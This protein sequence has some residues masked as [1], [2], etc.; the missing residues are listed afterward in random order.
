MQAYAATRENEDTG[1]LIASDETQDPTKFDDKRYH[2]A[3]G[4][5]IG[6]NHFLESFVELSLCD[7]VLTPPSTFAVFAAFLGDIPI[8]PLTE[9]SGSDGWEHLENNLFDALTHPS[10]S[11][12]VQ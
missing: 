10:L 5:G 9:N 7:L 11:E 2:F 6:S 4:E 8:V 12:S 3:T 1:F